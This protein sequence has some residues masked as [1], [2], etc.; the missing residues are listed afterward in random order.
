MVK[1]HPTGH[2]SKP[3]FYGTTVVGERGQTVIPAEARK[4]MKLKTGDKLLVF[5]MGGGISFTTLPL[6]S[7]RLEGLKKLV[8]NFEQLKKKS[9]S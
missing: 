6:L 8:S 2:S 3:H 5:G 1:K 4:D 9:R 7:R